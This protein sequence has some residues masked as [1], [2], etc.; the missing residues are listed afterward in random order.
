M[1]YLL[2][3]AVPA[4]TLFSSMSLAATDT[5]PSIQ[6]RI[7]GGEQADENAWPWIASL[8]YTYNQT[9][10]S[11]LVGDSTFN[12]GFFTGG[13]SG[14]ASASMVDCGLGGEQCEAAT[15]KICLIERG[16]FNFSVKASN[17]ESGG[18]VG[19]I[20]YNN[21][22]GLAQGTLGDDF[23]GTIP[24]IGISQA[25]GVLLKEQLDSTAF[26]SISGEQKLVQSSSCGASFIG[27]K[28]LL[29]AS[30]CVEDANLDFLQINIGEYDLS[31]GAENAKQIKRIYMHPDYQLG[32]SL[33]NDVALIELVESIDNPS[34]TLLDSETTRQLAL[35]NSQVTV[36]GWGNQTAYGAG[37]DQPTSSAP[38]I[39]RQVD[40]NLRSNEQCKDILVESLSALHNTT[41]TTE[42][43]G[44]TEVMLCATVVGGGKGS[45]Q[46]DSG[47]PLVVETNDGW[48]QLGVVSYGY[49]CAADGFPGVYARAASFSGWI[50]EITQGIAIDQTVD[51]HIAP[52]NVTRTQLLTVV[53]NSDVTANLTF[54]VDNTNF[55]LNSDSCDTLAANASCE[56]TVN[57]LATDIASHIATITVS[58][59]QNIAT[60]KTRIYAESIAIA[61][62]IK[63][64][65]SSDDDALTWFSGGDKVWQ[66]DTESTDAAIASGDITDAEASIVSLSFNGEGKLSFDWSVSSEENVDKPDEPFDA[67]YLYINGVKTDFISGDVAFENRVIE[68]EKG[69]HVITWIYAKDNFTSELNDKAYLKNVV[70][71]STEV[72]ETT[73]PVVT[74][75]KDPKARSNSGGGSLAWLSLAMLAG[76]ALVRKKTHI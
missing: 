61:D 7:V 75:P 21:D 42:Q 1:N 32:A 12:T 17:C 26:I 58:S 41:Y 47:G 27:D 24:V 65:L 71:T 16:D 19:V 63:T 22:T 18:G 33:N 46:G 5:P 45:C 72:K 76:L 64:Q 13:P 69:D 52:Q 31:D 8:V 40:L 50:N 3:A 59:D 73:P 53:N 25:D 29:T 54:D 68:L 35:D 62:E 67:F 15:D 44:I 38:D 74:T 70:F 49:G 10:A 23:S 37:E 43:V 11:L 20:I 39:L 60:S 55:T 14:E 48:Q 28:W 36:I 9:P 66:L 56:L 2:L 34:I 6:P 57:Y 30:H 51:F 4:M